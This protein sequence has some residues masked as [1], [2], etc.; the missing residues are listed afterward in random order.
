VPGLLGGK[1]NFVIGKVWGNANLLVLQFAFQ[2]GKQVFG[3]FEF[4]HL[5]L[6]Q[7]FTFPER[8]QR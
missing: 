7:T 2:L 4:K 6:Q 8:K 3:E 1:V 5:H